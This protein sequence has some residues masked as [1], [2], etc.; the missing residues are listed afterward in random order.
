MSAKLDTYTLPPGHQLYWYTIQRV[1]GHGGFG[2]TYLALDTNL[3]Q[4]VAIKEFLPSEIAVRKSDFTV[5][6]KSD[7]HADQY[8]C[9]LDRFL[10]EARTLANFDHP[11][12]VRV[13][14]VFEANDTAYNVMRYEEGKPLNEIFK[15]KKYMSEEALLRV[16]LPILEGLSKVHEQ[17]FIHR[18]VQPSNIYI[19]KDD[20][21]VL[22]DFG[23]A[24]QAMGEARSLTILI[25]P[26][27]APFEQY[28]SSSTEQ[29][30]WTDIYGMGAT[31]YRAVAGVAPIDAIERSKG[32]LG[33][34]RD[35]LVPARV[36][37]K[38]RYSDSFLAAIDHALEFNEKNRPQTTMEWE[39]ELR[40][41]PVT[42]DEQSMPNR[43]SVSHKR[44]INQSESVTEILPSSVE[45]TG[46]LGFFTKPAILWTVSA[47]L[48][49]MV[50]GM[51]MV[52]RQN[53]EN[54]ASIL[55]LA[56]AIESAIPSKESGR[57][58]EVTSTSGS[59]EPG[60]TVITDNLTSKQ[61]EL[62]SII[63]SQLQ[64][65]NIMQENLTKLGAQVDEET[66]R[67][68]TLQDEFN[69]LQSKR[70]EEQ[71]LIDKL[72]EKHKQAENELR[73]VK[74]ELAQ[75]EKQLIDSEHDRVKTKQETEKVQIKKAD[76]Q[77]T[78][79]TDIAL[80]VPESTKKEIDLLNKGMIAY[81]SGNFIEAFRILEPLATAGDPIAQ[82]K[83]ATL[84]REGRG[85]LANNSLSL[86]W[87]REAAWQ[88]QNE[89]QVAL[90]RM[91]LNGIGGVR[92]P[93]LAYTWLV[94]AESNGNFAIAPEMYE[95]ETLLQP[96]QLLQAIALAKEIE[97]INSSP[98]ANIER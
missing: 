58:E 56:P 39:K 28:Y 32:L 46:R 40:K 23:S 68:S 55:A 76:A 49:V 1:L 20:T 30:P 3:E 53:L 82:F 25:T 50:I 85:V 54:T 21:P 80:A 70:K 7:A 87:M 74:N 47:V 29:G 71:Q 36:V 51:G 63:E 35:V 18:D 38:G 81:E 37:G 42:I 84:Y 6:P 62:E 16:V 65:A 45:T 57:Y 92:D 61:E 69:T 97:K 66:T 95:A 52:V 33:S 31:L 44:D 79:K 13:Y 34:T 9:W 67:I 12:I 60:Q 83:I 11:N 8:N 15:Q 2:V 77:I 91:Y 43:S 90:A 4:Y 17:G 59:T 98:I 75:A 27:Y 93:F 94:V 86:R 14:S 22:L 41:E 64:Q 88:G 72:G 73:R 24:R 48:L 10:T 78:A 5:Q 89:A 19:R 26:G 96:E